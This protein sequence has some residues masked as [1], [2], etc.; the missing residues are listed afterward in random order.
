M[1]KNDQEVTL[2]PKE[3]ELL[4]FLAQNRNRV[5]SREELLDN[6]WEFTYEGDVRTIDIHVRRLRSK[7]NDKGEKQIIETVFGVGY[8]MR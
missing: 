2:K 3:Y 8:V 6:V 1:L 7:L 5:F 4:E